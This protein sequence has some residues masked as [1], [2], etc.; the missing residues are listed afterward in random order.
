M[1]LGDLL[2]QI[3]VCYV[4]LSD[5]RMHS[6]TNS[7]SFSVLRGPV[8]VLLSEVRRRAARVTQSTQVILPVRRVDPNPGFAKAVFKRRGR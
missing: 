2:G 3:R 6:F 1:T 7:L 8:Q 5:F 4:Y